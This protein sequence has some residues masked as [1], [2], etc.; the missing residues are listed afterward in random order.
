[1][2]KKIKSHNFYFQLTYLNSFPELEIC[3]YVAI[4][5]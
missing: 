3:N 5:V 1:M 4:N 2:I